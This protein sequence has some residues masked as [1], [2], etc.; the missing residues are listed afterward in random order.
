MAERTA[1]HRFWSKVEVQPDGCWHWTGAL[2]YGYGSFSAEQRQCRAHRFAYEVF[3]GP[4][5]EGFTIDHECHNADESCPGGRGC[6]HRRC[7]NPLHLATKSIEDNMN[8]SPNACANR[9]HCP[10]GHE[11]TPENTYVA[12]SGFRSCRTCYRA[13]KVEM[14][15]RRRDADRLVGADPETGP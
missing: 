4:I 8:A 1:L 9:T 6:L 11:Y 3:V 14:R 13:R 12:P 2:T 10:K 5:P 7:V 15:R